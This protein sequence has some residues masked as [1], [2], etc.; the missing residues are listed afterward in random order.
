[1]LFSATPREATDLLADFAND[2]VTDLVAGLLLAPLKGIHR[3]SGQALVDVEML[4]RTLGPSEEVF[5]TMYVGILVPRVQLELTPAAVV[6]HVVDPPSAVGPHAQHTRQRHKQ[7]KMQGWSHIVCQTHR[8]K[9]SLNSRIFFGN[10][11]SNSLSS[12][13][14]I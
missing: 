2:H 7:Q 8:L 6:I 10:G 3:L 11:G 13:S 4:R 14:I 12:S 9:M 5:A 1:M